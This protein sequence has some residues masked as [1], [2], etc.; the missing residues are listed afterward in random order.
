MPS[1]CQDCPII[2]TYIKSLRNAVFSKILRRFVTLLYLFVSGKC[3][4]LLC[5]VELF[6]AGSFIVIVNM[7]A[8]TAM[9]GCFQVTSPVYM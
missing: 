1:I 2:E 4:R 3:Y 9:H 5:S 7:S 6:L 8:V